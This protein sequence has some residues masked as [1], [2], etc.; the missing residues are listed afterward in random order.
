LDFCVVITELQKHSI[1]VS[2]IS[3]DDTDVIK[4]VAVKLDIQTSYVR[5]RCTSN[6][7]QEYLKN[8]MTN[9]KKIVVFCNDDTNN[10]VTLT[11]ADIS[12]HINSNSNITQTAAHVILMCLYLSRILMLLD[13]FK[14]VFHCI[15]FNFT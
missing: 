10:T 1:A 9:K 8:L 5:F 14:A 15:F 11:Q 3:D 13:L 4:A 6:N 7:K 2:I 12:M